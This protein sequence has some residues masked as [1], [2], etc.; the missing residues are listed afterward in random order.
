MARQLSA[1][2]VRICEF[3]GD[4]NITILVKKASWPN[5]L[6]CFV[7]LYAVILLYCLPCYRVN[8]E[9]SVNEVKFTKLSELC[10]WSPRCE[11]AEAICRAQ[12]FQV[13]LPTTSAISAWISFY[14]H[15]FVRLEGF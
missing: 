5:V 14:F 6:F 12:L 2:F 7:V 10:A 15:P 13:F 3:A 4:L 11:Q 9:H 8:K 1:A